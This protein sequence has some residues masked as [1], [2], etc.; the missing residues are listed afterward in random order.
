MKTLTNGKTPEAYRAMWKEMTGSIVCH[1]NKKNKERAKDKTREEA[2]WK[3]RE[4]SEKRK[5]EWR[6]RQ[7]K[8]TMIRRRGA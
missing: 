2:Q 6:G 8:N 5:R 1:Q 3:R 7:L 4:E